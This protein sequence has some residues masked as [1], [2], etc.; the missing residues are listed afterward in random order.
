MP[1]PLARRVET[2]LVGLIDSA[3]PSSQVVQFGEIERAG[4]SYIAVQCTQ[5]GEDPAGSGMFSLSLDVMA[6]GQHSQSD[7][8]TLEAIFDNCYEF[9]SAV[10]A[11]A[12]ASFVVPQGKAIDIDSSTKSGEGLDREY[13]YSFTIYAQTQENSDAA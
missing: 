12:T 7:I 8:A 6:H 1:D 11:A 2:V 5:L 4:K 9:S 10:R 13:R 3:L